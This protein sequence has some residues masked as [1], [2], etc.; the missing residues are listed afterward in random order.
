MARIKNAFDEAGKT[1]IASQAE[2]RH[3]P[4]RNVTK[5]KSAAGLDDT[6]QRC[7]AGVGSSQDAAHAG[8]RDVRDGDLVLL[9]HLQDAKMREAT[10][11]TSA[12]S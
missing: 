12:K 7:A 10:R 6:R 11:E 8:P 2:S 5:T 1:L 9:E 4:P 3:A